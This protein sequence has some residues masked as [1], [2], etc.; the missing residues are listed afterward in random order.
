[1]NPLGFQMATFRP[2]NPPSWTL[3]ALRSWGQGSRERGEPG[4]T[5]SA[6]GKPYGQENPTS[7]ASTGTSDKRRWE[8]S[9]LRSAGQSHVPKTAPP[10]LQGAFDGG[11]ITSQ[12][13]VLEASEI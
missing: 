9:Q 6:Y 1:M 11:V 3:S 4:S 10:A 12:E 8:P 7:V 13:P 2:N 5:P